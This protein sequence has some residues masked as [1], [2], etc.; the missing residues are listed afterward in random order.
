MTKV[1][2]EID[3]VVTSIEFPNND[4]T[5]P[6]LLKGF[7]SLMH[8]QT[9]LIQTIKQ[10]LQEVLDDYRQDATIIIRKHIDES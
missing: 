10:S 6:E 3:G 1:T 4:L 9:Y 7:C 2:L 5:G 8:G